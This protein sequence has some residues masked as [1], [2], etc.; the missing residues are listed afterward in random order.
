H[1]TAHR[2]REVLD[3]HRA[4]PNEVPRV[5]P[6]AL[7]RDARDVRL[8]VHALAGDSVVLDARHQAIAVAD[9]LAVEVLLRQVEADVAVEVAIVRVARIAFFTRPD[10]PRR[11]LIAR[12]ERDAAVRQNRRV[13]AERRLRPRARHAV[14]VQNRE[15]NA[16]LRERRV[17]LRVIRALRK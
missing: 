2:S 4:I 8:L 14:R 5:L 15:A 13:L 7:L 3:L 6:D 11:L 9:D 10:L 17:D 12:E 16:G 1:H